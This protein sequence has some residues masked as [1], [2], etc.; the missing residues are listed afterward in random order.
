MCTKKKTWL[1]LYKYINYV[2]CTNVFSD[3]NMNIMKNQSF[4]FGTRHESALNVIYKP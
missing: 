1:S 4:N 3:I 2:Q